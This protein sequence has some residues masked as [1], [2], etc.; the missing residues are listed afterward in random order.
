[1][2]AC[3][4]C[5]YKSFL[6]VILLAPL[7]LFSEGCQTLRAWKALRQV[8]FYID[9][10]SDVT[11]ADIA[12]DQ[13]RSYEDLTPEQ[14]FRL[15]RSFA[16][17]RL[18][19]RFRLHLIAENPAD[20]PVTARLERMEWTLLLDD[21]PTLSGTLEQ[22][23]RLPPGVPREIPLDIEL[24]L[25]DFFEENLPD[26]VELALALTGAEG[27]TK[28]ISLEAQPFIETPLG[29]LSYPRPIRILTQTVGRTS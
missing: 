18:P 6:L 5:K 25:L 9:H 13:V 15:S 29:P 12:L 26:L 11:L 20:N 27:K 23:Y 17:G 2:V 28:R 4:V 22:T 1:M 7:L 14:V 21:H 10:V 3:L 8:D 24:D 19:L 16:Q